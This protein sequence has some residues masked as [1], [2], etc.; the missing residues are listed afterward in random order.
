[1]TLRE[2]LLIAIYGT[3]WVLA[4]WLIVVVI[5]EGTNG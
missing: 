3:A 5:L 2:R 4:A 1:M